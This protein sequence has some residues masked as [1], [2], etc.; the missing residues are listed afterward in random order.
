MR[1]AVGDGV[2]GMSVEGERWKGRQAHVLVHETGLAD[3]AVA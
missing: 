3:A 1:C 2:G